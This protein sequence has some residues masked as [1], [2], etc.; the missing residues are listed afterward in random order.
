ML[1]LQSV[2]PA[3]WALLATIAA[4]ALHFALTAAIALV[5]GG[6]YSLGRVD[7]LLAVAG[8]GWAAAALCALS[9][10]GDMRRIMIVSGLSATLIGGL[11]A[12]SASGNFPWLQAG[13]LIVMAMAVAAFA[14]FAF[15]QLRTLIPAG[16]VRQ[17]LLRLALAVGLAVGL[18]V[19]IANIAPLAVRSLYAI[20]PRHDGPQLIIISGLPLAVAPDGVAAALRER[21][22]ITAALSLLRQ[23]YQVTFADSLTAQPLRQGT[24]LVLVH[25]RALTPAELVAIDDWVRGGGAALIMADGLSNWPPAYPIGDVRNP[26]LT[27]LLTPLLSHWGLSLDAPPGLAEVEVSLVDQGQ[28][29][30]L[31]SPG[32]LAIIATGAAR[33]AP[34]CVLRA[35]A[36][37]ADCRIGRGRAMIIA[38]A[39]MLATPHWAGAYGFDNPAQWRSGNILWLFAQLDQLAGLQPHRA[40][41]SVTKSAE[42]VWLR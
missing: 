27:S 17:Y 20:V 26:P 11:S 14:Q 21:P 10:D 3:R 38:D 9:L 35:N 40:A 36:M 23:R 15:G 32:S 24:V 12:I 7:P 2:A 28:R 16:N 19:G 1:Q 41:T 5:G 34:A 30:R 6:W 39:D 13:M 33:P 22:R 37:I 29:L 25:P 8:L 18:G 42:P 4:L 31:F